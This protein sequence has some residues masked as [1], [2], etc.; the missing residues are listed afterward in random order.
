[1]KDLVLFFVVGVA[2]LLSLKLVL[3]VLGTVLPMVLAL[4]IVLM[5]FTAVFAVPAALLVLLG[6]GI[7]TLWRQIEARPA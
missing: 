2:I 7:V 1:M 3:G 6:W 4:G 5:V